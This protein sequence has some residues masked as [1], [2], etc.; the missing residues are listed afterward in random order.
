MPDIC[1][2]SADAIAAELAIAAADFEETL[3]HLAVWQVYSEATP[4]G[5][6][7]RVEGW[8]ATN[9]PATNQPTIPI[10]VAEV[11]PIQPFTQPGGQLAQ[12]SGVYRAKV[13]NR[14]RLRTRDRL[15]MQAA[16]HGDGHTYE[17]ITPIDAPS[18][19]FS[20][21]AACRRLDP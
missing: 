15:V 17:V 20:V 19:S 3:P 2:G 18:M 11:T 7:G 12:V 8:L 9:D 6:G 10:S 14:I 4:D 13:P 16:P 1:M 21:A 5:H